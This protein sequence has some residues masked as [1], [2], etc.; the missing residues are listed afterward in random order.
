MHGTEDCSVAT[1]SE[2]I[3]DNDARL[4]VI[5][6]KVIYLNNRLLGS[7]LN[8]FTEESASTSLLT[9]LLNTITDSYSSKLTNI[10]DL[11]SALIKEI[12]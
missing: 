2:V 10:D 4:S 5:L 1:I 9:G 3:S 7:E 11:L 6:N 12:G 8:S